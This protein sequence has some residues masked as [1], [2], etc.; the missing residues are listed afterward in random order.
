MALF[1]MQTETY[2]Y[3]LIKDNFLKVMHLCKVVKINIIMTGVYSFKEN[4]ENISS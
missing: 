2:S 3:H 4:K 1:H